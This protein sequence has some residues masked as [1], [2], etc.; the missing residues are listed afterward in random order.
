M[1]ESSPLP[2]VPQAAPWIGRDRKSPQFYQG[3]RMK[4]D[5]H[6]HEQLAGMI[7][8][9][10]PPAGAA[11]AKAR[12]LDLG[13]GEGALSKRLVDLGYDVLAVDR[14][15]AAFR[16]AGPSF[17]PLDLDE[18]A[19]LDRFVDEHHGRF[20]LILA[21]EVIEH[22]RSPWTFLAAC[23]RL[24]R[25]DTHLILTTPNV[26]SWWSR[27][28]F[29]LTGD[30]WGFGPESWDDPGHKTPLPVATLRAMLRQC[31]FECLAVTPAGCL[32]VLWTYNWKRVLAS[33]LVLPLRCLMRG[34]KDGWVLCY[35]AKPAP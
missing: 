25:T 13:C 17:I 11:G 34:E 5:T 33:L 18:P 6:V 35:H 1:R 22:L 14:D 15:A 32:P 21:V 31:G 19:A 16:A 29:F 12:V 9:L 3:L 4:T 20:D 27:L 8:G 2:I 28:W 23:R 10:V 7:A 26:G 30:L 24:C